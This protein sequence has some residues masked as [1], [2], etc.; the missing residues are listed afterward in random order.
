MRQILKRLKIKVLTKKM[1]V[2]L[3]SSKFYILETDGKIESVTVIDGEKTKL[4][5]DDD[6]G[7][8]GDM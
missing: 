2:F 4:H 5:G 8:I 6:G 3:T 1:A 7:G